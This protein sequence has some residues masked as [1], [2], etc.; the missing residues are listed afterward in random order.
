VFVYVD[1][2]NIIS[3]EHDINEAC[4]HLKAEFEMKDLGQIKFCL[5]LQLEYFSSGIFVYQATYIQKMLEKFNM[6][7]V[8]PCKTPMV[9]R[10]L[11]VEKD[12]FRPREEGEKILG[13]EVP[14][15]IAVGALMYLANSTR[16]NIAFAVNL[17]ARYSATPTKRHWVGV[18]TIF[19]YLNGTRDLGLFYRKNQD[20]NLLG[21]TNAGYLSD[22][23]NAKSQT[24]FVFLN[25]GT[26][27]SWKLFKQT[28][29]STSTNHSEIIALYEASRECVWLRKM[30]DH[31][32]KSCGIG[33]LDTPT[34]IFEDNVAC[35]VQMKSG[36]IKN[37][38][39]KY[40]TPKLF[41]PHELQKNGEIEILRTKSC[42]NLA[43]LFTKSLPY[44]MFHKYVEGIGMI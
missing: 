2:I 23:H 29:V 40:I 21:Y 31:I 34:I 20:R 6:D 5:G 36:Y 9:V 15:L 7:K 22:P 25:G 11:E 41:Y 1:D 19:R 17:L 28:L 27:I 32:L 26:T 37:N 35:V 42:D 24:S 44:S 38:I 14:Y 10:S 4:H 39:T 18:T 13:S 30:V 33:A 12:P 43:D 8:Y 3:N 16:P